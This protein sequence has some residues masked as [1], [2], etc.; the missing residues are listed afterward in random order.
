MD[1][2][3]ELQS[4]QPPTAKRK[5]WMWSIVGGLAVI[6]LLELTC[7]RSALVMPMPQAW[8]FAGVFMGAAFGCWFGY[9]LSHQPKAKQGGW[10]IYLAI[11]ATP[12]FGAA[13]GSH[14]A[15]TIYEVAAFFVFDAKPSQ[16]SV[17]VN[18]MSSRRGFSATVQGYQ[19]RQRLLVDAR[20]VHVEIDGTLYAN[21]EPY[22]HP[23]RDCL[24][25]PIQIG[26]NGVMRFVLPAA[27]FDEPLGIGHLTSCPSRPAET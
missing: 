12:L 7:R 16:M 27:W 25:L 23:G 24:S 20:E 18:G 5:A 9:W 8:R 1:A 22:R 11:A 17:A 2:I 19:F 6:I 26:R 3:N 4:D 10:R 14:A 15:R 13:I 21:L